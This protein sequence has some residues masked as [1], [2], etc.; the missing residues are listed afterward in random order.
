MAKVTLGGERLGSGNKM[1]VDLRTYNRSTHDLSY[2]WRTTMSPGTLVPFMSEV[3]LPGDTFDIDLDT[4]IMTHPTVGPLF[5]SFKV[6]LDVFQVPVR[7]YQKVLTINQ[8][9]A[10]LDM[11]KVKL[12]TM[13]LMANS[14]KDNG[15]LK[16]VNQKQI[17]DSC[18]FSYL[19]IRGL[20]HNINED[21]NQLMTRNFNAIP[22][23]AYLDIYKNYYANKQEEIGMII[24]SE[25]VTHKGNAMEIKVPV[26]TWLEIET[27][28]GQERDW[29]AGLAL[30]GGNGAYTEVRIVYDDEPYESYLEGMRAIIKFKD[31]ENRRLYVEIEPNGTSGDNLLGKIY[32]IDEMGAYDA[33]SPYLTTNAYLAGWTS[34]LA[35][36]TEEI[37]LKK[38]DLEEIDKIREEILENP[39]T[40]EYSLS[41]NPTNLKIKKYLFGYQSMFEGT[42][43]YTAYT[44]NQN[45][46]LIKC[47]QSD[48][49]NNW[50]ATE[51]IDGSQAINQL[52]AIDTSSGE[53]TIDAL[54]ISKKVYDMLNHIAVA[55]GSIDDWMK[56]VYDHER[57]KEATTP[58]YCGG[59]IKELTFDEVINNSAS[60]QAGQSQPLGT[61]AGRG[62]MSNKHKGG[63]IRVKVDEHCY[64]MG[65]ISLTP[66]LDYSQGNKWDVNLKTMDDFHKPPMDG[67]GFQDL[68]TDQMCAIDTDLQNEESSFKS[69]GKQPAW[70]NYMTNVNQVRGNFANESE[71]FMTLNRRYEIDE[72]TGR[73]KDLTT[74]IDPTKF[75]HIFAE[76]DLSAQNFWV[77]VKCDITARRKMSAKIMPNL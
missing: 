76:T 58:I 8:L 37:S 50:L 55:G 63:K 61:L 18:I 38:F 23:I 16:G 27:E 73:I 17:H 64:I 46:L 69:A 72:T 66:R 56:A 11:S 4:L 33:N 3:G 44:K 70:I 45:G 28:F 52:T 60:E 35:A 34:E 6:Q 9:G 22:T 20:G 19:N 71:M 21:E 77:Q 62:V 12:P 29:A 1:K 13:E 10:G 43:F 40:S 65:I 68:I 36:Y 31:D 30:K 75:N 15:T 49:F 14:W 67:I 26:G 54:I 53:F 32:Y 74:Y 41:A 51:W 5:G 24:A 59:L 48:L 42:Q 25:E 47:Y 7:L 39:K 57:I 2:I